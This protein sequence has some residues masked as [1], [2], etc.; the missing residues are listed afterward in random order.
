MFVIIKPKKR[1]SRVHGT[2]CWPEV[3]LLHTS[4]LLWRS[5]AKSPE[6]WFWGDSSSQP[7]DTQTTHGGLSLSLLNR[8]LFH[9]PPALGFQVFRVPFT[10]HFIPLITWKYL[11]SSMV[12]PCLC[13]GLLNP[14]HQ[15]VKWLP[16]QSHYADEKTQG[17]ENHRQH[18]N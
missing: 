13:A 9:P 16:A 15:P 14:Q 2:V 3:M 17:R 11:P 7:S 6:G 10:L 5:S 8:F 1:T 12:I 18:V 4:I